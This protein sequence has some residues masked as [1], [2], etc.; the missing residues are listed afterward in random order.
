MWN[1]VIQLLH[2][3]C[4]LSLW[5]EG[6]LNYSLYKNEEYLLGCWWSCKQ[7]AKSSVLFRI[8]NN[9]LL[10]PKVRSFTHL[11]D[12]CSAGTHEHVNILLSVV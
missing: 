9:E 11:L 5:N 6:D 2:S 10:F 3:V 7:R 4:L 12:Y 8:A 1:I